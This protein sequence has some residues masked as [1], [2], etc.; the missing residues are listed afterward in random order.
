MPQYYCQREP[1]N[2]IHLGSAHNS[3]IYQH[4]RSSTGELCIRSIPDS[5]EVRVLANPKL[6][7]EETVV[8]LTGAKPYSQAIQTVGWETGFRW[9]KTGS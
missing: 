4:K 9:K 1:D 7:G 6:V 2:K 8:Y 5:P 3:L